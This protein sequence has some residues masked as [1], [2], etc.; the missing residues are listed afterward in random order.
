MKEISIYFQ[1][2]TS[3]PHP[4]ILIVWPLI[5]IKCTAHRTPKSKASVSGASA[6]P[7]SETETT[8]T[9]GIHA[10]SEP[11]ACTAA[12]IG[13]GRAWTQTE[14]VAA[15]APT[16][17]PTTIGTRS[18]ARV[19]TEVPSSPVLP[20]PASTTTCHERSKSVWFWWEMKNDCSTP[21]VEQP[22]LLVSYFVLVIACS[23]KSKGYW[24]SQL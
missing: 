19:P 20:R 24:C 14:T 2:S 9:V 5:W 13:S 11:E 1:S 12:V 21:N 22:Y 15:C 4:L 8:S 10:P 7:V 6:K 3:A 17:F 16:I 18:R 23:I